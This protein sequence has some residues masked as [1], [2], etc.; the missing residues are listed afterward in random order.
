MV[1]FAS[2]S[3]QAMNELI[4]SKLVYSLGEET[5]NLRMRTG[6]HSGTVTA[7]VLRGGKQSMCLIDS[8]FLESLLG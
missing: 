7:G 4:M 8:S 5:A 3:M 6:L 1:R 2:E